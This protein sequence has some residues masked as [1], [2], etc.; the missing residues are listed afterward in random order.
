M[1]HPRVYLRFAGECSECGRAMQTTPLYESSPQPTEA[2]VRCRECGHISLLEQV[3][4]K[5]VTK[6]NRSNP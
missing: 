3:D 4:S 1:N 5:A 6:T 2:W